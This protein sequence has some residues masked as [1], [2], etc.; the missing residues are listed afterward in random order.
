MQ[1]LVSPPGA[2]TEAKDC[3]QTGPNESREMIRNRQDL[4]GNKNPV[5]SVWIAPDSSSQPAALGGRC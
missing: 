3:P 2:E 4:G 5:G 1:I